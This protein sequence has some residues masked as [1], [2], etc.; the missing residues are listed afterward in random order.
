MNDKKERE[1][2]NMDVCGENIGFN[3]WSML[4]VIF[5]GI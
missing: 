4:N 1:I 2:N 5:L 3:A